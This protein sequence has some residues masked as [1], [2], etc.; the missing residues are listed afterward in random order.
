MDCENLKNN[1]EKY[2]N[3]I[4]EEMGY[5]IVE[6]KCEILNKQKTLTFYVYSIDGI[7]LDDCLKINDRLILPLEELD[8]SKGE[9]YVLNISSQALIDQLL[10]M[11]IIEEI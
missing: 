11:M 7:T 2:I 5:E 9:D 1:A 3:P 4:I 6:V 10:Q 8:I